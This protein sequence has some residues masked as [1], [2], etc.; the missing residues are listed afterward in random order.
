VLAER[1]RGEEAKRRR[2]LVITGYLGEMSAFGARSH[3]RIQQ[4]N[5]EGSLINFV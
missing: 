3:M 2:V 1:R 4:C 5:I